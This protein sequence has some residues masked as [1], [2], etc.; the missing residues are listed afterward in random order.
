MFAIFS[1]LARGSH[2]RR[3]NLTLFFQILD[4]LSTRV[5]SEKDCPGNCDT[6]TRVSVTV[7]NLP[8]DNRL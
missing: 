7:Y 1:K 4:P 8:V 2:K 3:A 6:F 5:H